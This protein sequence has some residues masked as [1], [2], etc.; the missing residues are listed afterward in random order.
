MQ[1]PCVTPGWERRLVLIPAPRACGEGP[2]LVVDGGK[3]RVHRSDRSP[4]YL[5]GDGGSGYGSSPWVWAR[6]EQ[7]A[8]KYP[9][10]SPS[11][12]RVLWSVL[13]RLAVQSS[14]AHAQVLSAP[15]ACVSAPQP[16]AGTQ[17]MASVCSCVGQRSGV[18]RRVGSWSSSP[19]GPRWSAD[20]CKPLL[21]AHA[22]V[23]AC[24]QKVRGP[25]R[26]TS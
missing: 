22:R 23:S 13:P 14:R 25:V 1:D 10:V 3:D 7:Q 15:P 12:C 11:V 24:F 4:E 16:H 19:S 2:G 8:P 21:Y 6:R 20:I 9:E 17:S 5:D 26:T 18:R